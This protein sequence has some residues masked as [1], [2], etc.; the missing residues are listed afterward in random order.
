MNLLKQICNFSVIFFT[1]LFPFSS[2]FSQTIKGTVTDSIGAVPFANI[3]IK[4]KNI[5]KQN[6]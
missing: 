3:L 1:I 5:I 4:N 6:K 2:L